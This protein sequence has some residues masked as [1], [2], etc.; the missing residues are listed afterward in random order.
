MF[1]TVL[2]TTASNMS[3]FLT[4]FPLLPL[5]V[6]PAPPDYSVVIIM[7]VFIYASLSWVISARK[8]FKGPI[9]N[10]SDDSSL[11]EKDIYVG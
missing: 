9:R 11:D 5:Y 3:E 8:W 2:P 4:D 10:L 6:T 1:P 7:S